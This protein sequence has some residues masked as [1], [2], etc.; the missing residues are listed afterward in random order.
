MK[1]IL[2]KCKCSVSLTV[3]ENK[4]Y[5]ESAKKYLLKMEMLGHLEDTPKEVIRKMIETDTII[6]IQAYDQTPIGFYVVFHYDY[7]LAVESMKKELGIEV[8]KSRPGGR[9]IYGKR[10]N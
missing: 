4:E 6:K 5:Y 9:R 7:D 2:E 8:N 10:E 1:Q 3:N